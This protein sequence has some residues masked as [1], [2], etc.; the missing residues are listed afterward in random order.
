ME[1][2]K[3][4]FEG[5]GTISQGK[6]DI[7]YRVTSVSQLINVIIPHFEKYPLLTQKLADFLLFKQV[8]NMLSRKEHLT[9]EGCQEIVNIKSLINDGLS[10]ELKGSFPNSISGE[11]PTVPLTE[12]PNPN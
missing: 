4:Y 2:I 9:K 6:M 5:A 7:I 3:A 12:I 1:R 8:V 10:N 11:R